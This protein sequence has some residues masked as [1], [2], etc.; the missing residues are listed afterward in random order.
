MRSVK[1]A[2][3]CMREAGKAARQRLDMK[4]QYDKHQQPSVV[5]AGK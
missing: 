1:S 3:T 2:L 5:T 4:T